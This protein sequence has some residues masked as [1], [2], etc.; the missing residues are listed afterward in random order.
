MLTCVHIMLICV[1]KMFCAHIIF[2]CC[3]KKQQIIYQRKIIIL[4]YKFFI[5]I[6]SIF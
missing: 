2:I 5:G 6:I 4:F 3:H 1:H